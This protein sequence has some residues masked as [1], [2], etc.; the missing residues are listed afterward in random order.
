MVA[1]G[2]ARVL[3][4]V[5][6][7]MTAAEQKA[8]AELSKKVAEKNVAE[9]LRDEAQLI[10]LLRARENNVEK[11]YEM[12]EKWLKWRQDVR[13]CVCVCLSVSLC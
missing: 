2:H 4:N 8:F 1:S 3:E 12:W 6:S 10:R 13:I 5:K 9:N 11:S 7:K